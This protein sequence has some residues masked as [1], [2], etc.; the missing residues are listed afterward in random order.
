MSESRWL[1][2]NLASAAFENDRPVA[3]LSLVLW[4]LAVLAGGSALI[5]GSGARRD[6][7]ARQAEWVTATA[8]T[9]SARERAATLRAELERE[10]LAQR[11]V[12]TEFLNERIAERAFSWNGLFAH[13]T[14]LMP[15]GVRLLN[16][17]PQ[18]FT[19]RRGSRAMTA[20]SAA[21]TRVTM[22]LRGEAEDTES[23][24]ELIDR[25]F[26]HPAFSSPNLARETEQKD[27]RIR[28]DLSVEYLPATRRDG[29]P[30][31]AGASAVDTGLAENAVGSGRAESASPAGGPTS[32]PESP[33][34]DVA[35]AG[36][37]ETAGSAAAASGGLVDISR[38]TRDTTRRR[39]LAQ[40]TSRPSVVDQLDDEDREPG[41]SP[42][43]DRR[44]TRPE[45]SP[46]G[47]PPRSGMPRGLDPTLIFPTALP[48]Y[49]SPSG[50]RR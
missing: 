41:A 6:A 21:T 40:S 2:P 43:G 34:S 8:E 42:A 7:S 30:A 38:V 23:L 37:A 48:P 11:N 29:E 44:L 22:R 36:A 33:A 20:P 9:A 19:L 28:F 12:R 4:I 47:A 13:L 49:A 17:S 18:G 26:A 5:I 50:G 25:L 10:D 32:R 16:L 46:P 24:L 14:E 31:L 27:S 45:V 1:D 3:R 15:R 35:S 39:E